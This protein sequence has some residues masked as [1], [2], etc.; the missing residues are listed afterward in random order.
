M[1]DLDDAKTMSKE[2]GKDVKGLWKELRKLDPDD[3]LAV[4]GLETRKPQAWV[5]PALG[6]LVTGLVV[7]AGLALLLAPKPG[8]QLRSD[9]REKLAPSTGP[10]PGSTASTSTTPGGVQ[11]VG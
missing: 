5:G 11:R 9:L 8:P 2:I 4:L 3:A 7:G 10:Q 1:F 6:G